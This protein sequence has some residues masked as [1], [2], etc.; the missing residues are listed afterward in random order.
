MKI[1][2]IKEGSKMFVGLMNRSISISGL[3]E[4]IAKMFEEA[5]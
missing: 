4:D 5:Q 3:V 2:M 1:M